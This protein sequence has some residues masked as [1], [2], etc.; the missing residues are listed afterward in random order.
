MINLI[1]FFLGLSLAMFAGLASADTYVCLSIDVNNQCLEWVLQATTPDFELMGIT[2]ENILY[3][4]TW[5]FGTV[6]SFWAIAYATGTSKKGISQ[7]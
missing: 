2:P 1:C 7:T 5:G 4:F 3:S 6:L